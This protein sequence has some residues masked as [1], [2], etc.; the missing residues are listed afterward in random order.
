MIREDPGTSLS[1]RA[2][3]A[4]AG[5]SV[6]SLR[7]FFPTQRLL[8]DTVLTRIYEEALPDGRIHDQSVPA[9]DRLVECL[10]H[11]LAPIGIGD[12]ARLVWASIFTQFIAP[13]A[14]AETR[15]N[16]L[17]M[18]REAQR[19]IEFWLT[20]LANEGA[21]TGGDTSRQARFLLTLISG[22]SIERAMLTDESVLKAETDS[23]YMAV[24]AI[25]D[26]RI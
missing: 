24:D 11:I 23:L 13:T 21:M 8:L 6:G 2:V 4:R 26:A 5:V 9:R 10:R 19:R 15:S 3:A 1:V 25:L 20:V 17:V 18:A 14:T 22:M 16:H 7:H 12:Q